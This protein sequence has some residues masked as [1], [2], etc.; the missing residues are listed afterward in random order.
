MIE[1]R[2]INKIYSLHN[3]QFQALS[4]INLSVRRGEIY[5]VLGKS[6]AG[7]STL[8]RC[9]NLLEKPTSG[10]VF[11]NGVDLTRLSYSQLR[12]HRHQIGIIFQHF[13]LLESRT[14]F[15]N[16]A[17]PLEIIHQPKKDIKAKVES[18]LALVGLQDRRHYFPSQLSGGQKQRIAIARAL[19][20]DPH[21]LL[22]DEATSAL[23]T[24]ST[25]AILTLLKKINQQL[26]LTILLITHELEVIKQICHRVGII[27]HGRLIEQDSTINIF[28]NPQNPTTKQLVQQA[29]HLYD[30]K[31]D[32]TDVVIAQLTFIG[33]ESDEPLISTLAKKF[34]ITINIL[35]ALIEKIQDNTVGFTICE[36]QGTKSELER[37]LQFINTT[38]VKAEIIS[39]G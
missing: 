38:S 29:L 25:Y 23:D 2:N 12:E 26:G 8:L 15:E 20:T 7:K 24:E 19:A 34:D 5:G 39:H 17:L 13:N 33:K 9:V 1:L 4:D 30:G 35:Q 16:V 18:L 11:V 3:E 27:D 10:Q 28:A 32:K 22:C 36:L 14:A 21:V 37:A 31:T 6:G